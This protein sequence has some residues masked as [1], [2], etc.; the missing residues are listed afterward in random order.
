MAASEAPLFSPSCCPR[1]LCTSCQPLLPCD[2]AGAR[3]WQTAPGVTAAVCVLPP[4][5]IKLLIFL[6]HQ[7]V[8][9]SSLGRS[10][11]VCVSWL[12]R[13]EILMCPMQENTVEILW[14]YLR[15]HQVGITT[16][17]GMWAIARIPCSGGIGCHKNRLVTR[18]FLCAVR[19]ERSDTSWRLGVSLVSVSLAP[20]QRVGR[21]PQR[22]EKLPVRTAKLGAAG[23]GL[24]YAGLTFMT[25]HLGRSGKEAGLGLVL[26]H[27]FR[28][29]LALSHGA[30]GRCEG[31]TYGGQVQTGGPGTNSPLQGHTQLTYL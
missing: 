2:T 30:C 28:G 18:V 31:F 24:G 17:V 25:W 19:S 5:V 13:L 7:G 16:A 26:A 9:P 23:T 3:C 20:V 27:G 21:H 15:V 10:P 22:W 1:A 14:E 6:S 29:G 12:F 4:P 11:C 8:A